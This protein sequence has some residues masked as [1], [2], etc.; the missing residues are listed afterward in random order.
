MIDT[1]S[2]Y[3]KE[4]LIGE[5]LEVCFKLGKQRKDVFVITKIWHMHNNWPEG[6]LRES[7]KNLGLDYVD[8][9]MIHFPI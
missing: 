1:A 2:F 4:E 9:Y 3:L 8:M 7:L 5:A 6:A